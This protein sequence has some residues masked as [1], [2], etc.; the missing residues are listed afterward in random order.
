MRCL[1]FAGICFIRLIIRATVAKSS[2]P[3][4]RVM[5]SMSM[6]CDD[7]CWMS[8]VLKKVI[9]SAVILL[10]SHFNEH[11]QLVELIIG[12]GF[13]VD[14]DKGADCLFYGVVEVHPKHMLNAGMYCSCASDGGCIDVLL[15]VLSMSEKA[16]ALQYTE[17]CPYG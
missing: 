1:C 6:I 16:L 3:L 4:T 2:M 5:H 11:E 15:T 13:M 9:I 7:I 8:G 14:L 12:Q 10:S 17:E